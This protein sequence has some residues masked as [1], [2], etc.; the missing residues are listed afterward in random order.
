MTKTVTFKIDDDNLGRIANNVSALG[1]YHI[2]IDDDDDPSAVAVLRKSPRPNRPGGAALAE[3][4]PA[5]STTKVDAGW[6]TRDEI[7]TTT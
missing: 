4:E 5:S 3:P 2:E 1:G 7:T 6:V